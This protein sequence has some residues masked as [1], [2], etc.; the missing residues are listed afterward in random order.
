VTRAR[1]PCV[2]ACAVRTLPD[3][4]FHLTPYPKY[5]LR[6][7][8]PSTTQAARPSSKLLPSDFIPTRAPP[9][10]PAVSPRPSRVQLLRVCSHSP[11]IARS[12][13]DLLEL[14][15]KRQRTTAVATLDTGQPRSED[16]WAVD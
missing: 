6:K 11:L 16:P 3:R 7:H 9:Q 14:P 5:T 8:C 12:N 2:R 10:P 13:V 1:L 4:T 15:Q